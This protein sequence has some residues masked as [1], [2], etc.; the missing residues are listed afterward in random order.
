M[1]GDV[2]RESTDA[3]DEA[4]P[5][6]R[7]ARDFGG[8]SK[9]A[10][11]KRARRQR[12]LEHFA[13]KKEAKKA[14]RK[15]KTAERKAAEQEAWEKLTQEERDRRIRIS[16]QSREARIAAAATAAAAKA[17]R[18]A[19]PT[20]SCVVDLDF[21]DL[22]DERELR[23]IAQQLMFSYAAN[24]RVK[25]PL[26]L[27]FTSFGGAIRDDLESR[28]Y[29]YERWDVRMHTESYLQVFPRERLVY[30][31]SEADEVLETIDPECVYVIGGLVDHNRHKGLCQRRAQKA[32]VRSVRLPIDEHMLMSQRRVL[33]VNHVVEILVEVAQD[34][35]WPRALEKVLPLR[36]GASLREGGTAGV[37][38]E[39]VPDQA[40]EP[41]C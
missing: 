5:S 23:S 33:A 25:A 22:M 29:G 1:D 7:D 30:L 2:R 12:Q 14:E 17:A 31:S 3:A 6:A 21:Q 10:F 39:P 24:R 37:V 38:G 36:R 41:P 18:A 27:H 34:G 19:A 4:G 26:Q 15:Q 11:K 35:D 20:A 13:A 9:S 40:V 16:Q 8:L 28:L 32:A